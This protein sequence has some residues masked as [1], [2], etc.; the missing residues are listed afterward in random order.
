MAKSKARVVLLGFTDPD[1]T[2]LATSAPTLTRRSRQL[3]LNLAAA[4]HW[5]LTK[6][7]AKSAFLHRTMNQANRSIYAIPVLELGVAPGECVQILKPAYGLVSAPREWFLEV[8]RVATEVC[9]LRQLKSDPCVWVLDDPQPGNEPRGIIAAHVDDF[10]IAG[11]NLSPEWRM[12]ME[13]FKKAFRWSP[14][15]ST[16]FLHCGVT[17]NQLEDHF[18]VLSHDEYCAEIKHSQ[19]RA[20]LG[21]V[22]WRVLQSAPQHAAKLSW[23][24]STTKTG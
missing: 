8:N 3:T 18:F 5:T 13:K 11:D 10:L 7:D 1:L 16:P 21:A 9:K 12:V 23:L 19:C 24:Q 17:I 22:Q 14:W 15:E 4:K 2:T 6:A 20:V